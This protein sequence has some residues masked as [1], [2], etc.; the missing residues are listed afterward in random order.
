LLGCLDPIW[1]WVAIGSSPPIWCWVAISSSQPMQESPAVDPTAEAA[2][3]GQGRR[4]LALLVARRDRA[5]RL[6]GVRVFSSY[7][8]R[9]LIRFAPT[10]SQRWG[11]RVYA[12]LNGQRAATKPSNMKML[13]RWLST[14]GAASGEASVPRMCAEA[15]LSFLLASRPTNC[16]DRRWKTRIYWPPRVRWVLELRLKIPTICGAIYRGF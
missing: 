16:S 3:S 10:G 11:E 9:F 15:S 14:M 6:A 7:G 1:R 2:G 5:R 13:N 8:G 4:W 12:N